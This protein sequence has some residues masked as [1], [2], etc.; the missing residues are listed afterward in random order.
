ML[1]GKV[2]AGCGVVG[3]K[4]R[5]RGLVFVIEFRGFLKFNKLGRGGVATRKTQLLIV[6]CLWVGGV[7]V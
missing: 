4:P 3:Q 6:F 1:S 2:S 7:G 5:F